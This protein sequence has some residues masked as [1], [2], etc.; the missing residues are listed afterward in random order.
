MGYSLPEAKK[1][2]PDATGTN[3]FC[4]SCGAALLTTWQYCP[5]CGVA[6]HASAMR[7]V[8][9]SGPVAPPVD[10]LDQAGF[11]KSIQKLNAEI[12]EDARNPDLLVR[13]AQLYA[14]V[15]V[16]APAQA[17]LR[18]ARAL[19]AASDF[20]GLLRLQELD[21]LVRERSRGSFVRQSALPRLPCW[22][23]ATTRRSP[24]SLMDSA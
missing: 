6:N 15:G 8:P 16:Y 9:D 13:R 22:F 4:T 12:A 3:C 2:V 10:S 11:E 7:P 5:A 18:R 20:S 14:S 19:L 17:D 24:H 1:P 23:K 21:R